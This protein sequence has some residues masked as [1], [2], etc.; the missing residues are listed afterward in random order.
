[1][2]SYAEQIVKKSDGGSDNVRRTLCLVGGVAAGL[3]IVIISMFFHL[4]LIGSILGVA[5][6][7]GGLYL[8]TNY[9]IEYEY[10]IVNGE[11]DIDKIMAKKRRK[12]MLTVN[13]GDFEDFGRY[14]N[15][16]TEA[17]DVTVIWAVGTCEENCDTFY[18]DFS[19]QTYGK[20]RLLFSPSVKVLRELKLSLKGQLRLNVGEL[21][22]EEEF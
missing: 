8:G 5:A 9:D 1:M 21:P 15:D 17:D 20:C 16:M 13:V 3:L 2:D 7:Y 22:P 14:S 12:K 4:T 19:H 10:L 18:A 6:F 11:F